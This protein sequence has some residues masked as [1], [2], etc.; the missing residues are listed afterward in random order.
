VSGSSDRAITLEVRSDP[1]AVARRGAELLAARARAAVGER[2]SFALALSGGRTPLAMLAHLR[3]HDIPWDAVSIWQVDERVAP[4]GDDERNLTHIRAKLPAE[5][6]ARLRPMPVEADGLESAAAAYAASLPAR[7]DLI[8]LG[9]G[10]DG[11]TASLVP[12]DPVLDVTDRAVAVTGVYQ[13]RRRMTFTY[14]TLNAAAEALWIIT[15]EDKREPVRLLL[16]GDPS[17]PSGRVATARQ[18]VVVDEAAAGEA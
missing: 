10:P 5:A 16:A 6:V 3:D 7:F 18:A 4:E 12:E 17:V 13:G 2:G 9:M 11:H 8:H 14:P 1:E 15:G